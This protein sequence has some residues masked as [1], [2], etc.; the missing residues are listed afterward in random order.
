MKKLLWI[1]LAG[2]AGAI[3]RVAI[4][5]IVSNDSGFPFSTLAV[6][7]VGT[8][9]LCFIVA[10]AFR[11]LAV[12]QE[13]QEIVT[14]GFLGSFTTFSAVSMET[15]LLV[16]KGHIILAGSYIIFSVIGGLTAGTLGFRL[17][18]KRVRT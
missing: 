17:G 10:G 8:F 12:H 5:N 2:A 1:G 9:L 7:I 6:N 18:R 15:V 13:L 3:I 11:K 16:E 4:G 14:T